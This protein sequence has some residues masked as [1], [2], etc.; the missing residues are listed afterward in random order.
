MHWKSLELS[1][2]PTLADAWEIVDGFAETPPHFHGS[3]LL[4]MTRQ[5]A[6]LA[7]LPDGRVM[8]W[9]RMPQP[10][11]FWK[12]GNFSHF[13]PAQQ[14]RTDNA[15]FLAFM[16]RSTGT[17]RC[18]FPQGPLALLDRGKHFD[19]QMGNDVI[20]TYSH[21]TYPWDWA[22]SPTIGPVSITLHTECTQAEL[23][24]WVQK[25]LKGYYQP[26]VKGHLQSTLSDDAWMYVVDN[27]LR[28]LHGYHRV[29][30]SQH[31]CDA[32]VLQAAASGE[33]GEL[34]FDVIDG[35][36]GTLCASGYSCESLREYLTPAPGHSRTRKHRW[37]ILPE[38]VITIPPDTTAPETYV[39][40][41]LNRWRGIPL[42]T[43]L[44]EIFQQSTP[45]ETLPRQIKVRLPMGMPV[46][47]MSQ[48]NPSGPLSSRVQ[49]TWCTEVSRTAP[50]SW[51]T[52]VRSEAD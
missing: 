10:V 28:L 38:L 20:L 14:V 51:H 12:E 13:R 46:P 24:A 36:Y 23:M 29:P 43:P 37:N 9:L 3:L 1:A 2:L 17:P 45:I 16:P 49:W 15:W 22:W 4:A 30:A 6:I 19:I 41:E 11:A 44:T 8:L 52:W 27:Q 47:L 50:R 18:S 33:F 35:D 25:Y 34:T 32:F 39:L 7:A 5:H 26:D 31:G 40:Q 48:Q 42:D 21:R